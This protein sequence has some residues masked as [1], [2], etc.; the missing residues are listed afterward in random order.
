MVGPPRRATHAAAAETGPACASPAPAHDAP[1][2]QPAYW[3]AQR[4]A[5]A[6]LAPRPRTAPRT[7]PAVGQ[8]LLD[9]HRTLLP[10]P[11]IPSA[12][13]ECLRGP[14]NARWTRPLEIQ[15]STRTSLTPSPC[16][17]VAAPRGRDYR[18]VTAKHTPRPEIALGPAYIRKIHLYFST[19]RSLSA[20]CDL[21]RAPCIPPHACEATCIDRLR[22]LPGDRM[23]RSMTTYTCGRVCRRST[24][25]IPIFS[26]PLP[27]TTSIPPP[28]P[29]RV[30]HSLATRMA[31]RPRATTE[32]PVPLQRTPRPSVT[33]SRLAATSH[34]PHA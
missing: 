1:A 32:Q 14:I 12:S 8:R 16:S 28:P 21:S 24:T 19:H 15:T 2:A 9:A 7:P 30:Y 20:R 34:A 26:E 17:G 18:T 23:Y 31:P 4:A 22:T 13:G 5:P 6:G 27:H 33:L 3:L 29:P 25:N 11:S 10:V